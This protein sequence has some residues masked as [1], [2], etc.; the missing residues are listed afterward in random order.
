[1]T[2]PLKLNGRRAAYHT[3]IWRMAWGNEADHSG[4]ELSR[5]L[6]ACKPLLAEGI[7]SVV[8]ACVDTVIAEFVEWGDAWER[9]PACLARAT[10][11][12]IGESFNDAG[13]VVLFSALNTLMMAD[14]HQ[15]SSAPHDLCRAWPEDATFPSL[16]DAAGG[17]GVLRT[18]E[19]MAKYPELEANPDVEILRATPK[20]LAQ[21][22]WAQAVGDNMA[23][24]Y[25]TMLRLRARI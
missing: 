16:T 12:N 21:V 25:V 13:K 6:L 10:W 23:D 7:A 22:V 1:M 14:P 15:E 24:Q 20:I 2:M 11:G 9:N 8:T 3:A 4:V 18:L 19:W 5:G 17:A